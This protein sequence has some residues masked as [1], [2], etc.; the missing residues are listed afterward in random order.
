MH[1][2]PDIDYCGLDKIDKFI[3]IHHITL[4]HFWKSEK[5]FFSYEDIRDMCDKVGLSLSQEDEVS[6]K[7]NLFKNNLAVSIGDF[8]GMIR[9]WRGVPM[10]K[11]ND[12]LQKRSE[13]LGETMMAKNGNRSEKR[14]SRPQSSVT[15]N[16]TR[17][18]S[19]TENKSIQYIKLQKARQK[20]QENK[21]VQAINKAKN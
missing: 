1:F 20:E 10:T 3:H 21:L 13:V 9:S 18:Q 14:L 12:L 2:Q 5:Q 19:S 6:L 15:F 16:R 8:K 11:V 4:E 7:C 17:P